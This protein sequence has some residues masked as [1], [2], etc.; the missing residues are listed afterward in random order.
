[1]R[2]IAKFLTLPLDEQL[3]L[4]EGV[5]CLFLA[6]LLLHLPFRWLARWLGRHQ[7]G[8]EESGVVLRADQRAAALSVRRALLRLTPRLPWHTTCLVRAIAGRM[9]LGRRRLPSILYLGAQNSSTTEIAAH[10]WLRCG[11]VDVIGTVG[12]ERFTPITAFRA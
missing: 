2:P 11:E 9:M 12:A 8:L 3:V 7:S 1:M 6:R 4:V 5:V 10:A